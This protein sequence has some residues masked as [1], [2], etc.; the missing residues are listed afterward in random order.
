MCCNLKRESC[1][2]AGPGDDW[3]QN[4]NKAISKLKLQKNLPKCT[5][6]KRT[7]IVFYDCGFSKRMEKNAPLTSWFRTR[8]Y[9]DLQRNLNQFAMWR[10]LWYPLDVWMRVIQ[11]RWTLD[12]GD[13]KWGNGDIR[14][15]TSMYFLERVIQNVNAS[16]AKTRFPS[17]WNQRC[18]CTHMREDRRVSMTTATRQCFLEE[19]Y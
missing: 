10:N 16:L 4:V 12:L 11:Y 17:T 5:R 19:G 14:C 13:I 15:H 2:N 1:E 18:Q 9:I 6:Y 8:H 3:Q 7:R